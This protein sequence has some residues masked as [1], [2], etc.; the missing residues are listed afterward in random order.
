MITPLKELVHHP[1]R[2]LRHAFQGMFLFLVAWTGW[3]FYRFY[4]TL[5]DPSATAVDR[6][7]SVEAFLPISALLALRQYVA[8]GLY[9]PIHPA[10]LTLLLIILASA[11]LF[12]RSFCSW[13][14]PIGAV[15]EAVS[16]LGQSLLRR[17][18]HKAWVPRRGW[19]YGFSLIKFLLL[20]FFVYVIYVAMD[21][22]QAIAF[23]QAPY[24]QVA[25]IKM[26][27]FFLE[28]SRITIIVLSLL[29]LLHLIIPNFW[30]RF[31]CPYGALLGIVSKV[32][33][34]K[35]TR[36]PE[37]CVRCG[38]CRRSC[39]NGLDPMAM[40]SVTKEQCTFCL[41]CVEQCP[42]Q[43]LGVQTIG[44]GRLS[45][46]KSSWCIAVGLVLLFSAGIILAKATGYWQGALTVDTIRQ[47]MPLLDRLDHY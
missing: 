18:G 27:L 34:T 47:W 17:W 19:A 41:A 22:G 16:R 5:L 1:F 14:C 23:L 15:N 35:L 40:Q 37:G 6:P 20:L 42:R 10:G 25:D 28:P 45:L 3:D 21:I 24:N 46:K 43:V 31:M 4:L 29:A 33:P 44:T 32:S 11:V 26:L 8:T 12:R 30:C 9:D 7:P 38:T 13:I 36:S 2:H 39:L